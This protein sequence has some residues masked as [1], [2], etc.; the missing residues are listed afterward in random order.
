[1]S[2]QALCDYSNMLIGKK[3]S[4]VAPDHKQIHVNLCRA[5]LK[6]CCCLSSVCGNLQHVFQN[7]AMWLVQ[8][9]SA[10]KFA[11]K[12]LDQFLFRWQVYCKIDSTSRTTTF[13]YTF[14]YEIRVFFN[15]SFPCNVQT[16]SMKVVAYAQFLAR[17]MEVDIARSRINML[18]SSTQWFY[19]VCNIE[20]GKY[21]NSIIYSI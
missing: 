5:H 14:L 7:S 2:S 10:K 9:W 4:I 15:F 16:I 20:F 21:L 3:R 13:L 11:A 6:N 17:G 12:K 1:M 18:H 19:Y 8:Y